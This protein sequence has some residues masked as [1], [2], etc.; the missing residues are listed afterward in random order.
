MTINRRSRGWRF[1]GW[2]AVAMLIGDVVAA[3]GWTPPA[4]AALWA[5]LAWMCSA[6]SDGGPA[7][8]KSSHDTCVFCLPLMGGGVLAVGE[9]VPPPPPGRVEIP[10]PR[11]VDA[12]AAARPA[13]NLARGPPPA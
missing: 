13:A 10:P 9:V 7:T 11:S 5:D 4:T 8:P 3:A 6:A 1:A 12:A 2:L